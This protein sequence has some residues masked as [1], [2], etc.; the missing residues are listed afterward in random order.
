ML[1]THLLGHGDG[2]AAPKGMALGSR[3]GAL[4]HNR[5]EAEGVTLISVSPHCTFQVD[6]PGKARAKTV[7]AVS[8][9]TIE[10]KNSEKEWGCLP[11]TWWLVER[12]KRSREPIFVPSRA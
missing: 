1:L 9:V 2:F 11:G 5:D 10:A 12:R 7:R 4:Y 6:T 3:N 8:R